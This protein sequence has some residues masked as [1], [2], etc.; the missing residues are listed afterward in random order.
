MKERVI[1]ADILRVAATFL[2]IA[3]HIISR[4]F[5]LYAIDSY[6]WQALNVFDSFARMSVPL[7]FMM[8]GIFFLDPEKAFSIK[9]FYK[10]NVFRLVTAFVFWSA[11][12]AVIF[13]WNEYRTFDSEVW[14]VMFEAFKEGHFHLWFL[15]RMIEIYVMI[16]FLRKIA[17]DKKM[18]LYLIAFCFYV[19]F[20]LPSYHE[21]PVS[22]TVTFAERGI[23]LDITFGYVGYFFA[24]YFLAHYDLSKWVKKAI[25]LLGVAGLISTIAITSVESLKQGKHYDLPYEYLTPNVFLMSIAAFLLAKEKL[26]PKHVSAKFK[27]ILLE[28]SAYSFGIYL[29]HVLIIFLLWKAG[30]T[31]LF[32][33]P[34]L[35]V[36]L[37]TLLVFCISYICIKGIAQLPFI[38][39][40]IL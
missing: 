39:R 13:T 35:S 14:G 30:V 18:I 9:K 25:Y 17:E 27:R 23:N 24:G 36:P 12:Y 28:L 38:K 6:Q 1:Y 34:F 22:S 2:V 31:T 40:F 19:G 21:F 37:L 26:N 20:V 8:S 7:F 11:L 3:I 29:V 5:D 33:T 32:S 16:P 10:K 4:D 15:F